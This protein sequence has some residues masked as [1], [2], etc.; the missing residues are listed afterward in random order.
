[1]PVGQAGGGLFDFEEA[2]TSAP[3]AVDDAP[4]RRARRKRGKGRSWVG[5]AIASCVFVVAGIVAAVNWDRIQKAFEE[6]G[7]VAAGGDKEGEG[8]TSGK[9]KKRKKPI[10]ESPR[11]LFPRRVLIVSIHDY[12]YAN[13]IHDGHEGSDAS[14]TSNLGGLI[15]ALGEGLKVPLTEIVHLSDKARPATAAVPPLKPIIEKGLID[16][17]QGSR[18]QDRVMVF[19]IGHSVEIGGKAYLMPVE[20]EFDDA[21]T[22]IPLK[23]VYQQMA[24]CPARQKVLVL[25]A[26]RYNPGQGLERPASGKMGAAFAKEVANAPAGVQV[27][28]ACGAKEESVAT[29]DA[30]IGVF[31][32]SLRQALQPEKR[33]MKG[34]LEGKF[35]EPDDLIPVEKLHTAVKGLVAA[36]LSRRKRTQTPGLVGKPPASGAHYDKAEAPARVVKL[37]RPEVAN[38]NFLKEVLA[39]VSVPPVRGG[40]ASTPLNFK[41]LP[42]LSEAALAKYMDA[43]DPGAKVRTA[44]HK[45]RLVLWA[46]STSAVPRDLEG[47]V[48]QLRKEVK[49]DLSIMQE[50]YAAPAAGRA[51][52]LFK[53]RVYDDG[54]KM[55]RIVL[56]LKE[57]LREYEKAAK[58]RDK[59][60]PRWQA[61][62][63]FVKTALQAQMAYLEEYQSLLGQI[64][65]ELPP[66]NRELYNGWRLASQTTMQGDAAGKKLA[67]ASRKTLTKMSKGLA[68]TP[69]GVLAKRE[70]LTALGLDWQPAR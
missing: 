38:L 51:E 36:D 40:A 41:A 8:E 47:E 6:K 48:A 63:D 33:G 14:F 49:V 27:W 23:W 2:E 10:G 31:L 12:L 19:F 15:R 22:L 7:K 66:L 9:G 5:V 11:G 21:K 68:G 3:C 52:N 50:R 25:D 56:T 64:R 45:A 53:E 35:Q 62:Y 20:G 65:K 30:P 24:R 61:N 32:E 17:L 39:E 18:K 1:M 46:V 58:E 42:P 44:V 57:T 59:A 29:D 55:A 43:G 54:R 34:A 60:T 4:Y 26:N 69:W 70:K 13:P 16:F 67:K 28:S 37:A